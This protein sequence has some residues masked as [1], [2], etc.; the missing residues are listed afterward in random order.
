MHIFCPRSSVRQPH[1]DILNDS[2]I[3][4]YYVKLAVDLWHVGPTVT[5]LCCLSRMVMSAEVEASAVPME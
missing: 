5:C 1:I 2:D 3:M 4:Y